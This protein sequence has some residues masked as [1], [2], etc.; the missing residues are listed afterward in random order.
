MRMWSKMMFCAVWQIITFQPCL[1]ANVKSQSFY[2]YSEMS[3]NW[4]GKM[5]TNTKES[6][7]EAIIVNWLLEHNG[8]EL[9]QAMVIAESLP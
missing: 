8:Y 7:F 4:R 5:N 6:G 1:L 3:L 9:G 2:N